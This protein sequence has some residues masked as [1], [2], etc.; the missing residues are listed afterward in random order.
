MGAPSSVVSEERLEGAAV[1]G[2]VVVPLAVVVVV[3]VVLIDDGVSEMVT[4]STAGGIS[5][6]VAV[7]LLSTSVAAVC[8]S[9]STAVIR[10]D[11]DGGIGIAV[12]CTSSGVFVAALYED[13]QKRAATARMG[14]RR[15]A[16]GTTKGRITATAAAKMA[17]LR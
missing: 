16:S 2:V 11:G 15:N 13:S 7:E 5:T 6:A 9:I 14:K 1:V 4:M 12:A 8:C 17:G 10:S 3:V